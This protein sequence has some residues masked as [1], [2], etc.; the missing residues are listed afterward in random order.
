MSAKA[1]LPFLVSGEGESDM[2]MLEQILLQNSPKP[3]F[4]GRWE[5]GIE[6][7]T[8]RHW[9]LIVLGDSSKNR[10]TYKVN[11]KEQRWLRK[12]IEAAR[13][14]LGICFGAQ[15]LAAY[16]NEGRRAGG[17]S[18]LPAAHAGVRNIELSTAGQTDHVLAS[19]RAS[20]LVTVSHEDCFQEP[21]N[22]TALAWSRC[23]GVQRHCE[24]FRV[25]PPSNAVYGLQFHPEPTLQML[26]ATEERLRWFRE[27]P[28][29]EELLPVVEAGRRMLEA[30]VSLAIARGRAAPSMGSASASST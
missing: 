28:S 14:V 12:A 15:L 4:E 5:S 25:G 17:L 23:Q 26:Q 1:T 27:I 19:L 11:E 8:S 9:G 2:G 6:F 3:E 22:A 18:G 7:D 20:A 29:Q 30:W 10:A 21:D 13:P 16:Q 24:A